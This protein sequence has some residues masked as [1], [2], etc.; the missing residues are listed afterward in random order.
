[1]FSDRASPAA[2]VLRIGQQGTGKRVKTDQAAEANRFYE[3]KLFPNV[4][5]KSHMFDKMRMLYFKLFPL[6]GIFC[7]H[8]QEN[9]AIILNSECI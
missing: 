2:R 6:E 9:I 7:A 4:F 3:V 1:M 5:S 8:E